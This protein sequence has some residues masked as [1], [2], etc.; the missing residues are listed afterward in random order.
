MPSLQKFWKQNEKRGLH[1]F[2]VECQ[3]NSIEAMERFV[4][5]KKMT[6]PNV[7][8]ADGIFSKYAVSN[9]PLPY[10]WVIG[11]D[12][13]VIFEGAHGYK[14][15]ISR[16]LNKVRYPGLGRNDIAKGAEKAA[17]FFGGGAFGKAQSAAEK[18]IAEEDDDEA[19]SDAE[20]IIGRIDAFLERR[21]TSLD[22]AKHERQYARAMRLYSDMSNRL[23]GSKRGDDLKSEMMTF[24]KDPATKAGLAAEA[25]WPSV[26]K[27]LGDEKRSSEQNK[28]L[29]SGFIKK[30]AGT[31]EAEAANEILETL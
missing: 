6:F 11:V 1:I 15:V 4:R 7:R 2:H 31:K 19:K 23:R 20:Y 9:L 3:D 28:K 5:A 27:M 25:A 14:E 12:G 30:H 17:K 22:E 13:S 8:K 21:R 29:L 16:E 18:V 26:S 10:A 24:K